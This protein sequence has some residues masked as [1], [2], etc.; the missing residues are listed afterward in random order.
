MT[1]SISES[2]LLEFV[3]ETVHLLPT[4]HFFSCLVVRGLNLRYNDW[5]DYWCCYSPRQYPIGGSGPRRRDSLTRTALNKLS[6]NCT[7]LPL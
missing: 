6:L 2:L 1:F 5:A 3:S 7:S 4:F